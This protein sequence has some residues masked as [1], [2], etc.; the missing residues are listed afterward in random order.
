[1]AKST[2]E[3]NDAMV[4]ELREKGMAVPDAGLCPAEATMSGVD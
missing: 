1:V 2:R 4:R 3:H